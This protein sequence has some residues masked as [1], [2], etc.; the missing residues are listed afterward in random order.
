MPT[1]QLN[2]RVEQGLAQ[3]L[4]QTA[5]AQHTTPGALVAQALEALLEGA[6]GGPGPGLEQRLAALE[7]RV[8]ALEQASPPVAP[9]APP[10]PVQ[11]AALALDAA[12]AITTAELAERTGTNKGAWNNWAGKASPGDVRHHPEAGP[13]R[14]VGKAA[15]PAGGPPRWIWQPAG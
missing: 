8:G 14:L 6:S 7:Q 5:K 2:V 12:G 3:R 1:C 10:H 15:P 11:Q 4:R 9:P 13:W